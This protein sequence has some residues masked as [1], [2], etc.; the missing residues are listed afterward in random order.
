MRTCE[1][2]GL[3]VTTAQPAM[4][5]QRSGEAGDAARVSLQVRGVP[6]ERVIVLRTRILA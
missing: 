2:E 3:P 4:R 1:T 5:E 6:Q